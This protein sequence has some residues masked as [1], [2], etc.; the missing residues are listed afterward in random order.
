VNADLHLPSRARVY[1]SEPSTVSPPS[2]PK[3]EGADLELGANGE[4]S[5]VRRVACPRDG[6]G[7]G[8]GVGI[9]LAARG[10][11]LT[12]GPGS[13][14]WNVEVGGTGVGQPF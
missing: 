9:G 11:I 7:L 3:R 12:R 8:F 10:R 13:S 4:A 5:T 2:R 1:I 6:A 14:S